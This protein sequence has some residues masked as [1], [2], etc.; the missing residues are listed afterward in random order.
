MTTTRGLSLKN[1]SLLSA[2]PRREIGDWSVWG[3]LPVFIAVAAVWAQGLI[4][5]QSTGGGEVKLGT[6]KEIY[7]AAC[8]SCHGPAGKGQPQTVLG[9]ALPSTFPDFSDCN[10]TVRERVF[11]WKATIHEGGSAGRAFSEIMPS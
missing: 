1:S 5:A 8:I 2:P 11:D 3:Y 7:G 9:F 6:G 4:F 10:G